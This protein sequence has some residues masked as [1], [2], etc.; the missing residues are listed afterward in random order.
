M[1]IQKSDPRV[2][3]SP[4]KT[5]TQ[6]DSCEKACS[7]HCKFNKTDFEVNEEKNATWSIRGK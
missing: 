5:Q 1:A 7:P 2:N 4:G 3:S 6:T